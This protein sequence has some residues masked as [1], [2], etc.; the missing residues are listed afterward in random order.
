MRVQVGS[1]ALLLAVISVEGALATRRY[2]QVTAARC[3]ETSRVSTLFLNLF[4]ICF[5]E[6]NVCERFFEQKAAPWGSDAH[7][8]II[9]RSTH[10]F[11]QVIL[12]CLV[13]RE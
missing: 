13:T 12:E 11:A 4:D 6:Q 10:V 1:F 5:G 7:D 8:G 2:V 9:P 3:C